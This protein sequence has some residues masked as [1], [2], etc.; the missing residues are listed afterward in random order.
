MSPEDLSDALSR[1]DIEKRFHRMLVELCDGEPDYLRDIEPEDVV[2]RV[3]ADGRS[4]AAPVARGLVRKLRQGPLAPPLQATGA[5][6]RGPC[7]MPQPSPQPSP[8]D[9][10]AG[11]KRDTG[12]DSSNCAVTLWRGCGE[13]ASLVRCAVRAWPPHGSGPIRRKVLT[14]ILDRSGSMAKE[15]RLLVDAVVRVV[16]DD[17]LADPFTSVAL[18]VYD[19][20]AVQVPLPDSSEALRD[21]LIRRYSPNR[22]ITCFRAAFEKALESVQQALGKHLAAGALPEDVDIAALLFTDGQDTSLPPQG[23]PSE[24]SASA[25]R[26]AGDAFRRGI[27]GLGCASYTSVAAFGEQHSPD[28][29]QYLSDRYTYINRPG[30]LSDWLAMGLDEMLGSAGQC[31][32][33]VVPPPGAAL[34]EPPPGSLP[35]NVSGDLRH[36]VWL[37]LHGAPSGTVE[38]EVAIT[39]ALPVRAEIDMKA[40]HTVATDSFEDHMFQLDKAALQMRVLAGELTRQRPSLQDLD[41]IRNRLVEVF[42][43]VTRT[44]EAAS[45]INGA[46]R[47]RTALRL[48]AQEVHAMR[49]RL[50]YAVGHFD[51]RD[52]DTRQMGGVGINA[53]LRDLGQ[54]KPLGADAAGALVTLEALAALPAPEPLSPYGRRFARDPYTGCDAQVLAEAGDALFFQL[55]DV[56]FAPSGAIVSASDGVDLVSHEAFLALSKDATAAVTADGAASFTHVGLPLYATPGHFL[57]VQQL[58]PQVLSRLA[59]VGAGAVG[60]ERRLLALLG[61]AL[62]AGRVARGSRGAA[63][64]GDYTSALLHK[65]RAV[66][67]VLSATPGPGHGSL[68]SRAERETA[69]LLEDPNALRDA[70]DL[71]A[72]AALGLLVAWPAS[73]VVRLGHAVAREALRRSVADGLQSAGEMQ[74]LWLGWTLLGP[75]E[76]SGPWLEALV[77]PPNGGDA[78]P[79]LRSTGGFNALTAGDELEELERAA[80]GAW[81]PRAAGVEVLQGLLARRAPAGVPGPHECA[82]VCDVLPRWAQPAESQGGL[83]GLWQR[84]DSAMASDAKPQQSGAWLPRLPDDLCPASGPLQLCR[85]VREPG[86]M[87]A[88]IG[89]CVR[90]CAV[91]APSGGDGKAVPLRAMV[92]A[93]TRALVAR[94][95]R[96]VQEHPICGAAYPRVSPCFNE[97]HARDIWG[98]PAAPADVALHAKARRQVFDSGFRWCAVSVT[99]ALVDKEYRAM[100]GTFAFP[101]PLDT[102]VEGLHRRTRDLHEEWRDRDARQADVRAAAVREMLLRLRWD[103]RDAVARAKLSHIVGAIWDDLAGVPAMGGPLSSALWLPDWPGASVGQADDPLR[104]DSEWEV[105]AS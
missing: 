33:R 32:L 91:P 47:G 94:R 105:V 73:Q 38:V 76:A 13:D 64:R 23:C 75:P 28:M 83:A 10:T 54:Q 102:F 39:G 85:V 74:R 97:E 69:E 84:L 22:G 67:A 46:L 61:R 3:C 87:A 62:A 14:A 78:G 48:R 1:L 4:I 52:Q 36:H 72:V 68:L 24:A 104:R 89:E 82:T 40:A 71:Y 26:A 7:S 53:V 12:A 16:T 55:H 81:A 66:H 60:A 63:S 79:P 51:A 20:T 56:Q 93:A 103:D 70:P 41:R 80:P 44:K 15:W 42:A 49:D 25:A 2:D 77:P 18:V 8:L 11:E 45:D 96:L 37:R 21:L 31:A 65:A 95:T 35:L 5:A 17:I 99:E 27:R 100:G 101:S 9:R 6:A 50:S 19:G 43:K 59:P 57:R 92:A 98:A 58:L 30:V 29:C 88:V 34:E 86:A 90:G